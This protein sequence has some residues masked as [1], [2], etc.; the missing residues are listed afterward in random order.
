MVW[1][2]GLGIFNIGTYTDACNCTQGLYQH[3]KSVLEL[4][5]EGKNPLQHLGLEPALALHLAFQLYQ[6]ILTP[7]NLEHSNGVKD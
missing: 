7:N 4:D 5:S 6:A 1:L 2:P 3:H